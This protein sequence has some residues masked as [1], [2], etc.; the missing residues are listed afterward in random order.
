VAGESVGARA[1]TQG[2]FAS[3]AGYNI[4]FVTGNALTITQ[5][6]LTASIANQNKIYGA[7][8]PVLPSASLNGLVNRTVTTWDGGVGVNDS[9]LTT[10][11]TDLARVAGENVGVRNIT[12]GTFASASG[13]YGLPTLLGSPSLTIAL[14]HYRR[15]L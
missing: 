15:Q 5:A 8:D 14:Q 7:D 2:T 3:N 6:S 12:G 4:S 1:I 13:N 11:V 9:T 10:S